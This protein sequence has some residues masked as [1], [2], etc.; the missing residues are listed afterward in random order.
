MA[1]VPAQTK[2]NPNSSRSRTPATAQE[3]ERSHELSSLLGGPRLC[4][5]HGAIYPFKPPSSTLFALASVS[6]LIYSPLGRWSRP[7]SC[8]DFAVRSLKNC[9]NILHV[10]IVKIWE[11]YDGNNV[12]SPCCR[13]GL[14]VQRGFLLSDRFKINC[15]PSSK[16][17]LSRLAT[18]R[19]REYVINNTESNCR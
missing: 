9:V 4:Q 7:W 5:H 19:Q 11:Q 12:S 17:Q 14:S 10:D 3:R 16:I 18:C 13:L 2:S 6:H 1:V 15:L 8:I